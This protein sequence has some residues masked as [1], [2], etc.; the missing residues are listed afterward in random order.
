V[1]GSTVVVGMIILWTFAFIDGSGNE[2]PDLLADTAWAASA[3]AICA[4]TKAG[5]PPIPERRDS[6]AITERVRRLEIENDGLVEMVAALGATRP[7][8]EADRAIVDSWFADWDRHLRERIGYTAAIAAA[9]VDAVFNGAADDKTSIT[10]RMDIFAA[11]N[12]MQSCETP[13]DL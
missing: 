12:D 3:E 9:G 11:T 8:V 2:S 7:A 13:D 4:A 10:E 5:L 6:E 1:L